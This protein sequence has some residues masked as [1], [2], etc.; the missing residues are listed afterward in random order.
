[1][2]IA[3]IS[4][5]RGQLGHPALHSTRIRLLSVGFV[6]KGKDAVVLSGA[7]RQISGERKLPTALFVTCRINLGLEHDGKVKKSPSRV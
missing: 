2:S 6:L 4:T 1:M 5:A 3:A 7:L